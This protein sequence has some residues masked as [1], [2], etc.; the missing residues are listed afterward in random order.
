M[1]PI[2][3]LLRRDTPLTLKLAFN[4]KYL[5]LDM[6]SEHYADTFSGHYVDMFSGH[7]VHV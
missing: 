1:L 5:F 6:F 4:F 7:H 2:A 3:V